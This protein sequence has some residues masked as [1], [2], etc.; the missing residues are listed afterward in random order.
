MIL[1]LPFT[2]I[3]IEM[4]SEIRNK[5]GRKKDRGNSFHKRIEKK[6]G[7]VTN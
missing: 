2:F 7:I 3:S 5:I 4:I 6:I 1:A